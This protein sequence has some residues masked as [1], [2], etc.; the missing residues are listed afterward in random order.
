MVLQLFLSG[1]FMLLGARHGFELLGACRTIPLTFCDLIVNERG[2]TPVAIG[3]SLQ[4]IPVLYGQDSWKLSQQLTLNLGGRV[5]DS[6]IAF[7]RCLED[8]GTFNESLVMDSC[9]KS[10][11]VGLSVVRFWA[12][13]IVVGRHGRYRGAPAPRD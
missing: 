8:L 5:K 7:P 9:L 6:S 11:S 1:S 4:L 10:R 2:G 13:F 3:S 12:V